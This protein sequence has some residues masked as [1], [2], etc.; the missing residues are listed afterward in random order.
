MGRRL[1]RFVDEENLPVL[2]DVKRP[3]LRHRP[4]AADHPVG[5]GDLAAWIA[6]DR[7]IDGQRLGELAVLL[8]PCRDWR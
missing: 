8:R 6:E 4:D 5:A 1:H 7:I 2:A 3:T